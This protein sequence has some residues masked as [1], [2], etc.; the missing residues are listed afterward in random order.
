[1]IRRKK[2]GVVS[3]GGGAWSKGKKKVKQR[4]VQCQRSVNQNRTKIQV[5]STGYVQKHNT[6]TESKTDYSDNRNAVC[7]NIV[8]RKSKGNHLSVSQ[9]SLKHKTHSSKYSF[10]STVKLTRQ[11]IKK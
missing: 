4:T 6:N 8:M 1:M 11:C 3:G 2:R 5:Y 10:F 7:R 9:R